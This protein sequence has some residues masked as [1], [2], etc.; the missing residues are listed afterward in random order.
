MRKYKHAL[1]QKVMYLDTEWLLEWL[2]LVRAMKAVGGEDRWQPA[3]PAYQPRIDPNL[4]IDATF[5]ALGNE[6]FLA[7]TLCSI[8]QITMHFN[9]C[10]TYKYK[11]SYLLIVK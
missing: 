4:I 10:K 2:C 8:I 9:T 6:T 1:S 7:A 11:S 5:N 3:D